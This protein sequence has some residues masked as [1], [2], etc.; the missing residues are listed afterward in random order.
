MSHKSKLLLDWLGETDLDSLINF[1][2]VDLREPSAWLG[3]IPFAYWIIEKTKPRVLVELGTHTGASYFAFC[4]SISEN[5]TGT[6]AYAVDTWVGDEHA[7]FYDESVFRSVEEA[8]QRYKSFS[9]LLRTT[10]D[11]ASKSFDDKSID[12]LHI[13]GLHTYEAVKHDFDT[14]FPKLAENAV[15]LF[16]DTNVHKDDFGVYKFWAEVA[17]GYP[18]MEFFHYHGLGVLQISKPEDS[19]IPES[20]EQQELVRGIFSGVS[21]SMLLKVELERLTADRNGVASE[22]D[23]LA[24]ERDNLASERDNLASE[25]DN[26]ASERDNLAS[27]RDNLAADRESFLIQRDNLAAERDR[28]EA[29]LQAVM[30]TK[31]WRWTKPLRVLLSKI[32]R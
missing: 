2:P 6:K 25:R 18:S 12:L 31:I 20:K 32:K 30:N 27:E 19:F 15:V 26:L 1:R 16:H 17:A 4:Q 23:N 11:E 5:K 10:F 29:D 9:T 8:N 7:G 13:D 21:E 28:L 24:S 14:W 3:H 22:R